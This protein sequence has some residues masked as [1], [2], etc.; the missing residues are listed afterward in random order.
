MNL[1]ATCSRDKAAHAL[2]LAEAR[3]RSPKSASR[4]AIS[5]SACSAV[6]PE[7]PMS[8]RIARMIAAATLLICTGAANSAI[9]FTPLEFI[10][11]DGAKAQAERGEITVPEN[12]SRPN[13]RQIKLDFV[14]FPALHPTNMPPIVY[15]AGG[16]GVSGVDAAR[17]PAR[18]AIFQALREVTDVIAFDQRGT[19]WSN[20]IPP[21]P[22]TLYLSQDKPTTRDSLTTAVR[23]TANACARFWKETGIDLAAY[24]T[25]ESAA[26]IDAL[27]TALGVK[28]VS[29]WG[30]SYGS[31]LGLAV[32]KRYPAN[33]E[34]VALVGIEGLD[35]T[36]KLPALT[37]AFFGRLQAAILADPEAAKAYPDF[38]GVMRRVHARV[39]REPV[40]VKFSDKAGEDVTLVLGV[41]DVRVAAAVMGS[42]PGRSRML[43]GLYA[44]M[45]AGD[46]SRAAQIVWEVLRKPDA[47]RFTGMGEAM[48]VAS[49]ISRQR[50]EQF[51][52]QVQGSLLGDIVNFPMP[53]I[54]D[55]LG[56][57][58]L[59]DRFRAPFR[60]D[61]PVLF[62]SGTLDGRT[63]PESAR[64]LIKHFSRGSHLIVENGGHNLFEASPLIKDV[65]VAWFKGEAPRSS[66]L[67][68]SPP[69]FTR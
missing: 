38:V 9:D 56:V 10:A 55:A 48:D 32:L 11:Q 5:H 44:M 25:W 69:Q 27:R 29:L 18:F 41:A 68:L 23:I 20:E 50:L 28:K 37:D 49:G 33:I 47:V 51:E 54:G 53:H 17:L 14:R 66:T 34:R 61:V 67:K 16:P 30:I 24:N 2:S 6:Q 22:T 4:W 12:R 21:C 35:E 58:D 19:G 3:C 15:L 46:F 63:Y 8:R 60:S 31:H 7:Y 13:G 52:R 59:G 65:V 39:E 42:D 62:M 45:D 40:S 43:P 57:P 64:E 36:V 1:M 26:D